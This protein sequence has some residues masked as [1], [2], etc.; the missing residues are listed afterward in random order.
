MLDPLNN[1][2]E[3]IAFVCR[4]LKRGNIIHIC[5]TREGIVHVKQGE[6]SKP[7]KI[8]HVSKFYE[9]FPNFVTK[10]I[11]HKGY[12][13]ASCLG[14]LGP[15]DVVCCGWCSSLHVFSLDGGQAS[16]CNVVVVSV[17]LAVWP[18]VCVFVVVLLGCLR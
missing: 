14:G 16:H 5:Y 11:I 7:F 2:N 17:M 6:S 15:I 12:L 4:K 3:S 9:L 10:F 8:F 1:D 13:V 18:G